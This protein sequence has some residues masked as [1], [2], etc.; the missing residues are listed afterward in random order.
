MYLGVY[1][2]TKSLDHSPSFSKKIWKVVRTEF[3]KVVKN[4]PEISSLM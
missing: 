1:C 2:L 3:L 4:F